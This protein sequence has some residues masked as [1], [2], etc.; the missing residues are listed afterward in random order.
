[1]IIAPPPMPCTARNVTISGRLRAAPHAIDASV[2]ANTLA[3]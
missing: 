1:V 3:M 2:K